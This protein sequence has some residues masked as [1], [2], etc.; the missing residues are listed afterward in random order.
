MGW[1]S[2]FFFPQGFC[3][4]VL[5]KYARATLTPIDTLRFRSHV[6]STFKE[7]EV[8]KTDRGAYIS[9]MFLQGAGW[10]MKNHSLCEATPGELFQRLPI[11]WMEPE[12]VDSPTP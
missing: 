4:S 1:I 3:T 6:M 9:G 7:N 10:D 12:T 2:G 8:K 11:V 5:Q